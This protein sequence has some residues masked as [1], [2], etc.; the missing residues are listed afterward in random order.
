M[1]DS[2]SSLLSDDRWGREASEC[3]LACGSMA[4]EE[5]VRRRR[6]TEGKLCLCFSSFTSVLVLP[7]GDSRLRERG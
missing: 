3:G 5:V 4:V 1:H 6:G 7:W 2:T